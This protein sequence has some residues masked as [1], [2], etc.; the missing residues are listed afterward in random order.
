MKNL[1]ISIGMALGLFA[2]PAIAMAQE[3]EMPTAPKPTAPLSMYAYQSTVGTFYD[4]STLDENDE[5]PADA[6]G[7]F[8]FIQTLT[9]GAE[10]EKGASLQ[11]MFIVANKKAYA[12]ENPDES[13]PHYSLVTIDPTLAVDAAERNQLAIPLLADMGLTHFCGQD[14]SGFAI[15]AIG[16][17]LFSDATKPA[18]GYSLPGIICQNAD[19]ITDDAA[20]N[21]LRVRPLNYDASTLPEGLLAP[22]KGDKAPIIMAFV[23]DM[24][25]MQLCLWVQ[26]DYM[27]GDMNW[28]FQIRYYADG[29]SDFIIKSLGTAE[30]LTDKNYR[31]TP[32]AL[33]DKNNYTTISN[34]ED[35]DSKYTNW[36]VIKP[37][38]FGW[39]G[40]TLSKDA[41]PA[42]GQT[43]TLIPAI[44]PTSFNLDETD[45]TLD[46]TALEGKITLDPTK[47]A[48]ASF[49]AFAAICATITTAEYKDWGYY[50]LPQDKLPEA[51][52]KNDYTQVVYI[53][54][55]SDL[56]Q[57]AKLP[58]TANGLK[59][60]TDYYIHIYL[61]S[62]MPDA[63][64]PY[65]YVEKALKSFGP[66]KTKAIPV[67][68]DVTATQTGDKVSLTFKPTEGMA[69]LIVKS[70]NLTPK[71]PSGKLNKGDLV[72]PS[73][74][75]QDT[76]VEL[77]NA[78]VGTAEL[79]IEA[80]TSFYLHLYSVANKDS[81]TPGYSEAASTS[82][83]RPA[84]TL[85][86]NWNLTYT[87]NPNI[88]L[89]IGWSHADVS[90]AEP[91]YQ[92]AAFGI[93]SIYTN[94]DYSSTYY[95]TSHSEK[96]VDGQMSADVITPAFISP[97]NTVTAGF[98]IKFYNFVDGWDHVLADP[99]AGD[100]I[101]IEY[102]LDN[103]TWQ[104]ASLVKEFP[105]AD[106]STDLITLWVSI[107]NVKDKRV[108]FRYTRYTA[109]ENL[110]N[111]I[112]S[113]QISDGITCFPPISLTIDTANVTDNQL[114]LRW[115]DEYN[116]NASY[117]I[118]YQEANTK[119]TDV[120][121]QVTA[122]E[123]TGNINNLK[124]LTAYRT[125]VQAVCA[126]DDSSA[127]NTVPVLFT[128]YAG[129]PYSE[130][131]GDVYDNLNDP[132]DYTAP[133]DRGVKTYTGKIGGKLTE[134]TSYNF[135][136]GT[137]N[138]ASG[139]IREK[140]VAMG[141][142]MGITEA[143]MVSPK[144]HTAT[145]TTLNF[146]LNS[147][148]LTQ[149]EDYTFSL[150][151]T[152][153]AP[154]EEACRL[155]VAVSNNGAFTMEDT[156]LCLT[157]TALALNDTSFEFE[158]EKTGTVQIAFF[159][160]NPAENWD[161][162][163][164]LEAYNLSLTAIPPVAVEYTLSLTASPAEGGTVTGAG[165]HLE[166]SDVTITATPNEGYD[167][168]AWMDGATQLATSAT[169]TFK[170][171]AADASYTAVFKSNKPAEEH[172]LTLTASPANGGRVSGAGSYL[173]DEEVTISA[174][175]ND[176]Y[177]FVAWLSGTDTLSKEATY[178]F[179]MPEKDTA[180][181]AR[182]IVKPVA[183]ENA[184][185]ANF[186]L[187]TKDGSLY[188]RNLGGWTVKNVEVYGLTGNRIERFTPNSRED[189]ILPVK[190]ERAMLFVRID[191]EKGAAVYKVYLH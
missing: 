132:D 27:V 155:Y 175:A 73:W 80:G 158:I 39:K 84:E 65:I 154:T 50:N 4:L 182:F 56:T 147:F 3:E 23:M 183:N 170:M 40:M 85:P 123:T 24:T 81:E 41:I 145:A 103:G 189:L 113:I 153:V 128:T 184:L 148:S 45:L 139:R 29:Q 52:F 178:T 126:T 42:E 19:C 156:V 131:L 149:N 15:A 118:A 86:I 87:S 35:K 18:T 62:H 181:T 177:V 117:L 116:T 159:F 63:K 146:K 22:T 10:L 115:N 11:N 191:T 32:I 160:E 79:P 38:T 167:F 172:L 47:T 176:G 68:K 67:V 108:E 165:K 104:L 70:L 161:Y 99:A 130:S 152:G 162:A 72:G 133:A 74:E 58:L 17:I 173:A 109:T 26:F 78:G 1:W 94:I 82:V 102:R 95:L 25:K 150:K 180:F 76:V 43:L 107:N 66:Y 5:L 7:R 171:P 136:W 91:D 89:P 53:G 13:E 20:K 190:A 6:E 92:K 49:D 33:R 90:E 138:S 54:K 69:T 112:A 129:L 140:T 127:F 134:E 100:S 34:G 51:N 44:D 151:E 166:G 64:K 46:F 77:I 31:F 163:F 60:N 141:V 137:A 157:G 114:T 96:L 106:Q 88:T 59:P 187:S 2:A 111:C 188:I 174:E 101:R 55:P 14:I 9:F 97:V 8:S 185:R 93:K 143:V 122:S 57:V 105:G 28:V 142:H 16:G 144:I 12:T 83:Y 135:T 36:N 119:E 21:F 75:P 71:I 98:N 48:S 110:I 168:V 121:Q 186:S 120:W 125:Q 61:Y 37:E 179:K 30:Q 169:Y 164:N 124:P